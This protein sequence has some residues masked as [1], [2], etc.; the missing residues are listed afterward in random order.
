VLVQATK[1]TMKD[2]NAPPVSLAR[3]KITFTASTKND[4]PANRVVVPALGGAGDPT[5]HGATLRVYNSNGTGEQTTV[6]LDASDWLPLGNGYV[7]RGPDSEGPVK[8][9]KLTADKLSVKGGKSLWSYTLD[10]PAQGRITVRLTIGTGADWCAESP[11]KTKGT[12][13]SSG[14]NDLP[15][16]FVGASKAPAP[17]GCPVPP[18]G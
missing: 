2:D 8:S 7:Y 10:E 12:P 1:L 18:A 14:K 4:P 6:E 17:V 3:R 5:V 15:D 11:A 16:K 9:V 13:P